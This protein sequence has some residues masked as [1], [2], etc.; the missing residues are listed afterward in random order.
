MK[1]WGSVKKRDW[2]LQ[3]QTQDLCDWLSLCKFLMVMF[4]IWQTIQLR[5][6]EA[7]IQQQEMWLAAGLNVLSSVTWLS[8]I[9]LMLCSCFVPVLYVTMLVVC[10]RVTDSG[11]GSDVHWSRHSHGA[12]G[13]SHTSN[14][15]PEA[16]FSSRRP[17][18][19]WSSPVNLHELFWEYLVF[20][21]RQHICLERYMLSPVHP[22]ISPSVRPSHGWII[23]KRLKLG[24]WNFHSTVDPSL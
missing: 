23:Q 10:C 9:T 24:L 20:S 8:V 19:S 6:D 18:L 16:H 13:V 14:T 1:D 5:S 11:S 15:R 4:I 3:F 22:S 2:T 21:V 7:C 12:A 17:L